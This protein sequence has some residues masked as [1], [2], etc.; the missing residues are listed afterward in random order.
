M[1]VLTCSFYEVLIMHS[2]NSTLRKNVSIIIYIVFDW[3]TEAGG[4]VLNS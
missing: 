2:S 4:E 1:I 3:E